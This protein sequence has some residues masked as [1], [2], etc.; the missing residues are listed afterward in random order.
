MSRIFSRIVS[1]RGSISLTH[2]LLGSST[3]KFC[4]HL[5][6]VMSDL[7]FKLFDTMVVFNKDF[8]K[9]LAGNVLN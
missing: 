4:R 7:V 5:D 8:L 2:Y 9:T 6:P 3:D 1:K